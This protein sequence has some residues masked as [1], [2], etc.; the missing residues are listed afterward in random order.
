MCYLVDSKILC[1]T[2]W[3]YASAP[4]IS[5]DISLIR[6]HLAFLA[7]IMSNTQIPVSTYRQISMRLTETQYQR[8]SEAAR[9]HN[10]TRPTFCIQAALQ[11]SGIPASPGSEAAVNAV[12]RSLQDI[13]LEL[14]Q[15]KRHA[16][17]RG[18]V[19]RTLVTLLEEVFAVRSIVLSLGYLVGS[20]KPVQR[21]Q[22]NELSSFA[23]SL[24]CEKATSALA[25]LNAALTGTEEPHA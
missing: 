4:R 7:F 19:N 24:K 12:T 15:L 16:A 8:I 13:L 14:R 25:A 1:Q 11:T 10:M 5:A 2:V 23:D 22:I 20:G 3:L 9:E 21:D 18:D 6:R 17:L